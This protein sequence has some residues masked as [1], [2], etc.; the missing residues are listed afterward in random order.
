MQQRTHP[1]ADKVIAQMTSLE[2]ERARAAKLLHDE[3]GQVLTAVGLQLDVLRLDFK[4]R[5]PEIEGRTIEIQQLLERAIRQVRSISQELGPAVAEKAG[6]RFALEQLVGRYRAGDAA[7][8][9]LMVDIEERLPLDVS[10]SL[11]KIAGLALANAVEHSRSKVI[12]VLL[13]REQGSTVLEVRDQG[14]GFCVETVRANVPGLGLPLM[15]YYASQ[16]NLKLDMLSTPGRGCVIRAT[17]AAPRRKAKRM[18][19]SCQ[20]Q[21]TLGSG[22]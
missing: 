12:E 1:L 20:G 7:S 3:V 21:A 15:E 8:I 14:A 4:D 2:R 13:R 16:A 9:R 19:A 22:S 11:C 18:A 5:Y 10:S 17:Y 6:L